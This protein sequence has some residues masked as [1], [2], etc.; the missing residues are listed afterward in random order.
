MPHIMGVSPGLTSKNEGTCR[1]LGAIGELVLDD[2]AGSI[3]V[4]VVLSSGKLESEVSCD[5]RG[6]GSV[7]VVIMPL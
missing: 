7:V 2:G 5:G 1:A 6:F 4:V 3:V